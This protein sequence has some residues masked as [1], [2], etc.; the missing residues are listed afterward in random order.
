MEKQF[1]YKC[2]GQQLTS[3]FST[4]TLNENENIE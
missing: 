2:T 4:V 3:E 1:S